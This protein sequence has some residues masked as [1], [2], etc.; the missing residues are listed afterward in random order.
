MMGDADTVCY[1]FGNVSVPEDKT[2]SNSARL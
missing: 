2:E 1:V